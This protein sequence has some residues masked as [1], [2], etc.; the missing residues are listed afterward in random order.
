[1][2]VVV[3]VSR[4]RSQ[5]L[6]STVAAAVGD[7][8]ALLPYMVLLGEIFIRPSVMRRRTLLAFLALFVGAGAL[9]GIYAMWRASETAAVPSN[10]QEMLDSY[11]S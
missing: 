6:A 3:V 5:S 10:D 7:A 9:V 2:F 1:L 4:R 11:G 8:A